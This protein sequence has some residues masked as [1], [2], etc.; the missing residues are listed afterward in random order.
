MIINSKTYKKKTSYMGN[1]EVSNSYFT[2]FMRKLIKLLDVIA[3][4]QKNFDAKSLVH[5]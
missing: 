2:Y 1:I 4:P 5:S 3:K